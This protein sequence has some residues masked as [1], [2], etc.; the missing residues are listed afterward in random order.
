MRK[1]ILLAIGALVLL[2]GC[3][4]KDK[5]P[6]I[7]VGP[8]WKGLPYRI[9]F[10]TAEAKPNAA[11]ITIPTVKYTANPDALEKRVSLVVMFDTSGAKKEGPKANQIIMAPTDISGADGALPADYTALA[12]KSLAQFLGAYCIKGKVKISV[13]LA[14]SSLSSQADGEEVDR[15]RLSDWLPTELAFK[16]THPGC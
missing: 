15:K 3:D 14:R 8:K 10:D 12:D 16:N 1:G 5:A 11:G 13:A 4:S 2:A 7:P 9:S 6:G